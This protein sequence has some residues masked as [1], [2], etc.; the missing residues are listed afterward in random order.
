MFDTILFHKSCKL[1]RNKIEG[2]Y[3]S[4][5]VEAIRILRTL[6]ILP[7]SDLLSWLTWA[8]SIVHILL[9]SMSCHGTD[10]QSP[11]V[12]QPDPWM[13]WVYVEWGSN[14]TT[15]T[16]MFMRKKISTY[17]SVKLKTGYG[18]GACSGATVG[19][20]LTSW[21]AVQA[22]TI[23]STSWSSP[24]HQMWLRASDLVRTTPGYILG[25]IHSTLASAAYMALQILFR[26][27]C[28]LLRQITLSDGC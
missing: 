20:F 4:P 10:L 26:T 23:S 21:Q 19:E 24:G 15:G 1:S 18:D 25:A 16:S 14:N 9:S 17:K 12:F 13:Q 28:T 11:H 3:G 5:L 6:I 2:H 7:Q 27:R 22:F 8:I